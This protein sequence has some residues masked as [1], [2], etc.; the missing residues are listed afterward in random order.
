MGNLLI[1]SSKKIWL[2]VIIFIIFDLLVI[3]AVFIVGTVSHT[4]VDYLTRDPGTVGGNILFG[5]LSNFGIML[6]ASAAAVCYLGAAILNK[7]PSKRRFLL[8]SA[9]LTTLLALDDAFLLHEAVIP[10]FLH[11]SERLVYIGYL[12]LILIYFILFLRYILS[13]TDYPILLLALVFLGISIVL[14]NL[15][16]PFP[17][18]ALEGFAEDSAK[19]IGITFWLLYFFLSIVKLS[20]PHIDNSLEA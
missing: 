1:K 6:W 9:L 13:M 4:P 14:D 10:Y 18:P 20:K 2:F 7:I 15:S 16:L 5:I 11:V 17:S 19:F 8:A 3:S 12:L